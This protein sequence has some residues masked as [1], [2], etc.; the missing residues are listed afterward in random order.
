[1]Q[2]RLVL[3]SVLAIL[4]AIALITIIVSTINDPPKADSD[5]V[6]TPEDTAVSITLTGSDS[7]P[8]PLTFIL[9]TQP[10][11]GS[12]SGT[13]PNLTYTPN[14]NFNGQD[15]LSF[16]VNDGKAD[17]SAA[18]ISI[19]VTPVN[20]P[21]QAEDDNA[22]MQEDAPIVTIDV[23]ANDTDLDNDRLTV[24]S[25][26][27]GSNGS[28]TI[29]ASGTLTYTPNKNFCGTDEFSY[30]VSDGKGATDT[31]MVNVTVNAVNDVPMITSKPKTTTR[32][33][34]SYTYDVDA[35][36]PDV[37]DTL[38]YSLTT[39]P[40]GMT[41]DSATGL[42]EFRPTSAQDGTYD[43]VVKLED[44]NSI[45]ASDIQSF[46]ITVTSLTSP[47]TNALIVVDGYNQE[48]KENLSA[49]G[50]T[51]VVQ[52][53]DNNRLQTRFGSYISYDFSDASIPAGAKIKSVVFYVE[54]FEEERFPSGKLQWDIG[55]GWPG[56]PTIWAST[57]APVRNGQQNEAID[58]WD[59]TSF[60]STS[61]KVDSLQLRV[62]N[63]DNT[64][65]RK[66]LVDHIYAVVE[67][68]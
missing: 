31:A 47:L 61:E 8:D 48:N 65:K 26:T 36:D 54:H 30:T 7:D 23:L 9:I 46:V 37:E 58:S 56:N 5:S 20:D 2:R 28:V 41:I 3:F 43:V 39:K 22:T 55:T 24:I 64:G 63:N 16:K 1:M 10:S 4:L 27:Q 25:A 34:A 45:P 38:T 29:N 44:S 19:T 42:I 33:W 6:T 14:T 67:W 21:L 15:S 59:V 62:R 51:D 68:Y 35:K 11:H 53:S 13:E 60:V 32:V 40:E 18:T 50:K 17:S 66:T 12:L 49:Q 57:N 52:A